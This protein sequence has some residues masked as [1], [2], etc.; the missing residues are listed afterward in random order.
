ML[1]VRLDPVAV[2]LASPALEDEHHQ[3]VAVGPAHERLRAVGIVQRPGV[4]DDLS[5][6]HDD[7][8]HAVH[9]TTVGLALQHVDRSLLGLAVSR[10]EVPVL[11]PPGRDGARADLDLIGYLRDPQALTNHLD[12]L[13]LVLRDPGATLSCPVTEAIRRELCCL[14][15]GHSQYSLHPTVW[16][17]LDPRVQSLTLSSFT[18]K[19]EVSQIKS[20]SA[21]QNFSARTS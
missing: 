2:D 1:V 9:G 5:G 20:C 19:S 11:L 13:V 3:A 21:R 8:G 10:V 12:D 7:V 6:R 15:L 17:T 4:H 14:L 18:I 16:S